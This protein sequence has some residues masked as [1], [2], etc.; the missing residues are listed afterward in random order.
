VKHPPSEAVVLYSFKWLVLAT[1]GQGLVAGGAYL[2]ALKII[3]D[4]DSGV[5]TDPM[6]RPGLRQLLLERWEGGCGMS[7][8]E[9]HQGDLQA[10][11]FPNSGLPRQGYAL[12]FSQAAQDFHRVHLG[13]VSRTQELL[14]LV[15]FPSKRGVWFCSVEE[16][17]SFSFPNC[18][19]AWA[20]LTQR[21]LLIAKQSRRCFWSAHL[22]AEKAVDKAKKNKPLTPAGGAA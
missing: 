1:F 12:T 7:H 10:K 13:F 18:A 15:F 8:S 11:R 4:W 5:S 22:E 3:K 19:S 16:V 17:P 2:P 20:L 9:H 14:V 21:S 6:P